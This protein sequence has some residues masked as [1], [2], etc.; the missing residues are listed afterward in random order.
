ML[1]VIAALYFLK[2]IVIP[3]TLAVVIA[4]LL[5]PLTSLMRRDLNVVQG[6]TAVAVGVILLSLL[7]IS[8]LAGLT[9]NSVDRASVTLPRQ[10]AD[11]SREL[12]NKLLMVRENYP[13]L[14][15]LLPEP[16]T[17][18]RLGDANAKML[19]DSL[20][21]G[22][23]DVLSW[24]A[25]A[26]IVL[27]LVIFIL[28]ESAMLTPKLIRFFAATPGDAASA[29][30]A[31]TELTH[32]IRAYLT[33]RT[34]I[35]IGLGAVLTVVLMT[36]GLRYAILVGLL[37]AL[38]NYIPY[39]GQVVGGGATA[40]L[41]LVQTGSFGDTLIAAS[42]YLALVGIEG[43][44]VTPYI[45]G[46]SLDL[47][48]TTVLIA[49]LFWGF[50]WG[51]VGLVLAMPITVCMKLVFQKVPEFHRWA[52]LMSRDWRMP[53]T[54]IGLDSIAESIAEESA[55]DSPG[56][57]NPQDADEAYASARPG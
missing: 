52:E 34:L 12:G 21:Y 42:I 14:R 6:S 7:P 10:I 41:V 44:I 26:F 2:A 55:P 36:M 1:G 45:M 28:A 48:G 38:T 53:E 39:V 19:I 47:N 23:S 35:N 24:L 37:A 49:C 51:L 3:I 40:L 13:S 16:S 46:R 27:M 30:R 31:L 22:F 15:A 9:A 20:S 50:L 17:I 18:D 57:P 29:E 56:P 5:S 33:A 43:Y 25:Q 32:Q 54:Q 11:L 8:Y 4:C